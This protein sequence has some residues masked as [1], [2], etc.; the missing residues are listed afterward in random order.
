MRNEYIKF[1]QYLLQS[2]QVL[3]YDEEHPYAS[4]TTHLDALLISAYH[5]SHRSENIMGSGCPRRLAHLGD[6]ASKLSSCLF[7]ETRTC[8]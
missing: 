1:I 5:L 4:P 3:R 8:F 7:L 2:E 6:M